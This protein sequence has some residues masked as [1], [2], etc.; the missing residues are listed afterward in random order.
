VRS[1][2]CF[3]ASFVASVLK[4]WYSC[5]S[6]LLCAGTGLGAESGC[7]RGWVRDAGAIDI[8]FCYI[9]VLV[10]EVDNIAETCACY[11]GWHQVN[12]GLRMHEA[13]SPLVTYR[14]R[15]QDDPDVIG[16]SMRQTLASGSTPAPKP[17]S[18]WQRHTVGQQSQAWWKEAYLRH[19]SWRREPAAA[20]LGPL[21]PGKSP[22]LPHLCS[23]THA[24]L[25][26]SRTMRWRT[27]QKKQVA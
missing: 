21:P 19:T 15:Q 8:G 4:L 13:F 2:W 3:V 1:A 25:P 16:Q 27:S 9:H 12:C 14:R 7:F 20:S 10:Q 17:P 23:C 11:A 26:R 18:L 5:A 24:R 6:E 22:W